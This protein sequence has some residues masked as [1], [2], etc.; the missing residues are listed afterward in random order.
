VTTGLHPT[1]AR[2]VEAP[3][4][5]ECLAHLECGVVDVVPVGDHE[6]F[7][8]QV[9]VAWADDEAFVEGWLPEQERGRLL[10]HL[11]GPRYG[12]LST[13]VDASKKPGE[14]KD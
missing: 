1:S 12:V 7:V 8:A 14:R 10:H 6:L 5:E 13:V 9:L 3:W 11:G 4:I 2:Q